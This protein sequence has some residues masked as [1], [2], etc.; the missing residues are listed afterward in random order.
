MTHCA[1]LS[2]KWET[3]LCNDKYPLRGQTLFR[4]AVKG[5]YL[6]DKYYRVVSRQEFKERV[7]IDPHIG[8]VWGWNFIP[9]YIGKTFE[10]FCK[11]NNITDLR[12][13]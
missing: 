3:V 8:T 7:E 11:D 5:E 10:S 2:N 1:L 13:I 4:L 6:D 12:Q 9:H